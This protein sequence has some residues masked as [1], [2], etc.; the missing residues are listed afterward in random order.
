MCIVDNLKITNNRFKAEEEEPSKNPVRLVQTIS[1]LDHERE[2]S[3][4]KDNGYTSDLG[5]ERVLRSEYWCLSGDHSTSDKILRKICDAAG[6]S[7][8]AGLGNK[9]AWAVAESLER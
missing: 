8:S 6:V 1:L 7:V 3:T 9:A 5:T 4:E 2:A